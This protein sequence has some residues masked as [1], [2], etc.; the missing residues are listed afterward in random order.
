MMRERRRYFRHKVRI[1]VSVFLPS[2]HE[3]KGTVA[4]LSE[5]GMAVEMAQR[6]EPNTLVRVRFALT[7]TNHTIEAKGEIAWQD[8]VKQA[9]IRFTHIEP[10][11]QRDLEQWL[12]KRFDGAKSGPLFINATVGRK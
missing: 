4:N 6:F 12:A 3:I 2:G 11:L 1:S 9:G 8:H 10:K 7:G 5:N